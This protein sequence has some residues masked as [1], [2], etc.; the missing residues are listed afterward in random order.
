MAVGAPEYTRDRSMKRL[1][2]EVITRVGT[3]FRACF[4]QG[5]LEYGRGRR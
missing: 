5:D 1:I 4:G 3:E 2:L